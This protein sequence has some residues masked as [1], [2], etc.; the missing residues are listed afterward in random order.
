MKVKAT[1]A[2]SL[3]LAAAASFGA[4]SVTDIVIATVNNGHLIEMQ[5]LTPSFE[6]ANP[7]HQGEV[8]DVGGG[9]VA[10]TRDHRLRHHRRSV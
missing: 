10:P 3:F 4:A 1:L 8:G 7:R 2:A 9:R 5:K 6:Q